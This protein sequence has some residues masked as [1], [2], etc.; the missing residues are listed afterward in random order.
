VPNDAPWAPP[1]VS[2]ADGTVGH[3]LAWEL[4]ETDGSWQAWVSWVQIT[5]GRPVHKV[6]SVRA[7]QLHPLEDPGSYARV[8]RRV[9]CRDGRIRQ[10]SA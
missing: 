7:S 4:F 8:P 9:R 3:L 6:V 2:F 10:W 1:I 5:A